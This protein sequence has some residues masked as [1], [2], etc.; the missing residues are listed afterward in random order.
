M[1]STRLSPLG[2]R[3]VEEGVEG[4]DHVCMLVHAELRLEPVHDLADPVRGV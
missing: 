4:L 1:K 2:P 3:G